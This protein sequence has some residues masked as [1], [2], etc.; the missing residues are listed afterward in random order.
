MLTPIQKEFAKN[1]LKFAHPNVTVY[2]S[3]DPVPAKTDPPEAIGATTPKVIEEKQLSGGGAEAVILAE[4]DLYN[5]I[6]NTVPSSKAIGTCPFILRICH[7]LVI[8]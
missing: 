6:Y 5:D 1:G 3:P 2:L 4:E 7:P 8:N